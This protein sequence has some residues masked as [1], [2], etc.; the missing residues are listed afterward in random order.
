MAQ[1]G[2]DLKEGSNY[3]LLPWGFYLHLKNNIEATLG[4]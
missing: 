3:D 2:R 1:V 4:F